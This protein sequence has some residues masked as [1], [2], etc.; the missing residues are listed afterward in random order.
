LPL[1]ASVGDALCAVH[2]DVKAIGTCS[3]CGSFGCGSCLTQQGSGWMCTKCF[4]V[5]AKL[6]WDERGSIGVWRA[7]WRT[8]VAMLSAPNDTLRIAEPDADVGSSIIFSMISTLVGYVPTLLLFLPV[9]LFTEGKQS[10]GVPGLVG[11]AVAGVFAVG[12]YGV[13]LLAFE[14][15]ALIIVSGLE[16]FAL[17][18]V[19]SPKSY[20]VTLRA[21]ALGTSACLTGILPFCS[22]YVHPLW[23]IILRIFALMHLHKTSGGQATAGVLLPIG[24]MCGG[25]FALY[26]AVIALAVGLSH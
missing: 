15:G 2:S 1:P 3:R 14:L 12:F 19:G 10:L 26:A 5:V 13:F 20:S 24:L 8:A 22:L 11:G 4:G 6:P 16:H 7:W 25:F 23:S 18:M 21:H 17:M 9:A